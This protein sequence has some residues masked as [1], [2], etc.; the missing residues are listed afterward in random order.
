MLYE[1]PGIF[2]QDTSLIT[3]ELQE[4]AFLL[5]QLDGSL[6]RAKSRSRYD[7]LIICYMLSSRLCRSTMELSWRKTPCLQHIC[8]RMPPGLRLRNKLSLNQGGLRFS[9]T[10]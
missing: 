5:I 9:L 10:R 3:K 2:R 8:S 6:F 7:D 1:L 4:R